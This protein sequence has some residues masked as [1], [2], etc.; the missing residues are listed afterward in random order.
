MGKSNERR[1]LES[2]RTGG[3]MNEEQEYFNALEGHYRGLDSETLI[4]S[5]YNFRASHV[6][7]EIPVPLAM[8]AWEVHEMVFWDEYTEEE[9]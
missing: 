8:R 2:I 4:A 5:F 6:T 3:I 1:V 7:Q 9:S